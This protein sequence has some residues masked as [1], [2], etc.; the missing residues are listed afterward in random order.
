MGVSK[1]A[2]FSATHMDGR[3]NVAQWV[4]LT[5]KAIRTGVAARWGRFGV[6]VVWVWQWPSPDPPAKPLYCEPVRTRHHTHPTPAPHPPD[7]P[8]AAG[9]SGVGAG[10]QYPL[11]PRGLAGGIV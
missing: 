6:G 4:R 10:A 8:L 1:E 2:S 11:A 9:F 5:A 7:D 3:V